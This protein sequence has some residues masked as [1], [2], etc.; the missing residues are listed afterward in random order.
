MVDSSDFRTRTMPLKDPNWKGCRVDPL[1][2][3]ADNSARR[4]LLKSFVSEFWSWC[5]TCAHSCKLPKHRSYYD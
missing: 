1:S 3:S 4:S 2:R 5:A